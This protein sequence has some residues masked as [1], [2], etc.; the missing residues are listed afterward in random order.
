MDFPLNNFSMNF[1]TTWIQTMEL[2][3][4]VLR[5]YACLQPTN[6]DKQKNR[7]KKKTQHTIVL[8]SNY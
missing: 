4:Y 7:R 1:S 6:G 3:D 5:M 8:H 2:S